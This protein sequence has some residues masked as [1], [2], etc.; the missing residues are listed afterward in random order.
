MRSLGVLAGVSLT[1]LLLGCSGGGEVRS[2]K[3]RVAGSYLDD[4]ATLS[5]VLMHWLPVIFPESYRKDYAPA[6]E[7]TDME[8]DSHN[9][10]DTIV[11]VMRFRQSDCGEAEFV[12]RDYPDGS[13]TNRGTI[14]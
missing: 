10:G 9:E 14:N 3:V 11:T 4:Q 6:C 13:Y 1:L 7:P 8:I 5:A 2:G 12:Q